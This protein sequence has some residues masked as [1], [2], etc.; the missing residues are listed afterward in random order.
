MFLYIYRFPFYL[1]PD[2]ERA[3]KVCHPARWAITDQGT[4]H[5]IK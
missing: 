5:G 2:L 1:Y 4:N 3:I